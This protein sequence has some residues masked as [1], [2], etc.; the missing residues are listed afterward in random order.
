[1]LVKNISAKG[2]IRQST[3]NDLPFAP[4]QPVIASYYAESTPAQTIV[5]LPFTIQVTGSQANTDIFWLFVDGKKLT[6]GALND[7]AFTSVASDGTSSQVTLNQSLSSGLNIQAFKLGLKLETDFLTDNRFT[8]LYE[9]EGEGFQAFIKTSTQM[10]A[11]TTAGSP[12]AGTFYSTIVGRASITDLT[13]D[14]KARMGIERIATQQIYQLQNEFGPNGEPVWATPNDSVGQIRFVGG[15]WLIA[16]DVNGPHFYSPTLN[17]F[18]EITFYGTGLNL[19]GPIDNIPRTYS[20]SVDGGSLVVGNYP[21]S[22]SGVLANRNTSTNQILNVVS[23]LTLGVH[24]VKIVSTTANNFHV[25]G[26]EIL[27][28]SSSVK[29]NPGTGYIQDKKYSSNSQAVFA[30]NS[31]ATSTRGGRVLVYQNGDGTI[32]KAWQAVNASQANLTSADHT[33]EEMV[34]RLYFREFGAGRADD[35]SILNTASATAAFTLDDDVTTLSGTLINTQAVSTGIVLG[36]GGTLILTFVG[37]GLDLYLL[38]NSATTDAHSVSIDGA[39]SVGNIVASA[40][41]TTVKIVSGLPYGTHTVTITRTAA[42]SNAV[43]FHSF[44]VY[45]PKKPS[46]PSGAVE[47]ADYNVVA[48]Y[49]FTSSTTGVQIAPDLST[50]SQGILSKASTREFVYVG[51]WTANLGSTYMYGWTVQSTTVG[52]YIELTFF[53]TGVELLAT[54]GA[55]ASATIMIDGVAYTGAATPATGT[56]SGTWTPG[57]STWVLTGARGSRLS[58]TGLTLGKHTVRVTIATTVGAGFQFVGYE[59]ITPIHS[60]K[61]NL[62]SDLQNTLMVGSNAISD[63]RKTTPVKDILPVTKAWAQAVGVTS[64]PT[65]TSTVLIPMPDMSCTVKTTGNSIRISYSAQLENNVALSWCLTQAYVDGVAVGTPRLVVST[66]ANADIIADDSIRVAVSPGVHSVQL[67][68]RVSG[69]TG[70]AYQLNRSLL[71]EEI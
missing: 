54:Y 53:G 63:N 59:T 26:F 23:G 62:Y 39:A 37:T 50:K 70:V 60:T 8:Q 22:G 65:T 2:A 36:N 24:T 21:A 20:Y 42:A 57:T 19:L 64:S 11:T 10:V 16:N 49:S 45:Q 30:Y 4:A 18:I 43:V 56:G 27:N 55:S 68:W 1:M 28:E 32:G 46:L 31:V 41:N 58:I 14:L 17:D 34:R 51:T 5:N 6:L 48:D 25:Y 12:V 66:T 15:G 52:N 7:Y 38:G 71:V 29:V 3:D 9:A 67:Y 40:S 69:S 35:F 44:L 61:S 47:V 33:N 13:Q